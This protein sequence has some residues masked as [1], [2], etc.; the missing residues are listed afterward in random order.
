MIYRGPCFLTVAGL[1]SSPPPPR[2]QVSLSVSVFLCVAGPVV[3]TGEG[4][5]V[6]GGRGAKSN[7]DEIAWSSINHSI[8]FPN[9]TIG[10]PSI[11]KL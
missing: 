10:T 11:Q 5:G 8:L 6:R 4:E 7:K 2:Q 1:G 9:I 3:L